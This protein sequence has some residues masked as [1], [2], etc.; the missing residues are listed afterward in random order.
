MTVHAADGGGSLAPQ[1]SKSARHVLAGAF[2]ESLLEC[3]RSVYGASGQKSLEDLP[4]LAA[5]QN[6]RYIAIFCANL[7]F[8]L[9]KSFSLRAQDG[10]INIH[11]ERLILPLGQ[12][13]VPRGQNVLFYAGNAC[14]VYTGMLQLMHGPGGAS[15]FIVRRLHIIDGIV[16]PE[17]YFNL[18]RRLG[19]VHIVIA[20]RQTLG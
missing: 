4:A 8:I 6:A 11:K 19:T 10:Q 9:F 1:P 3:G 2:F 17:R 16:K 5:K 18:T 12:R 13:S 15:F 14:G 20:Q 7:R